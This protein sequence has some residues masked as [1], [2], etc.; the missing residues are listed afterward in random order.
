MKKTLLDDIVRTYVILIY[1]PLSVVRV[2]VA[3]N[4]N[5]DIEDCQSQSTT[6]FVRQKGLMLWHLPKCEEGT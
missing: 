4:Y 5:V 3:L 1:F 6:V 2:Y